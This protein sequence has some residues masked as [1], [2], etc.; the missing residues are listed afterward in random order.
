MNEILTD[1]G[2]RSDKETGRLTP[3]G[4]SMSFPQAA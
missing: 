1:R 4:F 3:A 2:G